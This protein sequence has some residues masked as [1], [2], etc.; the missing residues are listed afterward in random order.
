M[1]Q[2]LA[3]HFNNEYCI[4][5]KRIDDKSCSVSF[6]SNLIYEQKLPKSVY[7]YRSTPEGLEVHENVVSVSPKVIV[8]PQFLH[9]T[10]V[11]EDIFI[12][13]RRNDIKI[14]LIVCLD[15]NGQELKNNLYEMFVMG[16]SEEDQQMEG[17]I[18][19]CFVG[20]ING[21]D[22]SSDAEEFG[23]VEEYDLLVRTFEIGGL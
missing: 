12:K 3:F 7:L 5:V 11:I 20:M 9:R 16:L 19:D 15:E 8:C 18:Y 6:P 10:L 1:E 22:M 23:L 21:V 13:A 2:M 17:I 4:K 14:D